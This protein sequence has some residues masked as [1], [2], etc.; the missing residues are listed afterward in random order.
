MIAEAIGDVAGRLRLDVGEARIAIER[1]NYP[2]AEARLESIIAAAR[3]AGV[4][5]V[6]ARA[7]HDRGLVAFKRDHTEAAVRYDFEALQLFERS[8]DQERAL[9]DVAVALLEMGAR[10]DARRA[11]EVLFDTA[12]WQETK[13]AAAINLMEIAARDDEWVLGS[14]RGDVRLPE[15]APPPEL[16]AQSAVV[17]GDG[18]RRFRRTAS[19]IEA[20]E[21]AI[22]LAA[23][24]GLTN[25]SNGPR[26]RVRPSR[27][28]RRG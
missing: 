19:A 25:T 27:K 20:Y 24:A 5:E 10:A 21:V 8:D 4:A 17:A 11:F 1:G 26:R 7:L 22:A 15:S 28:C 2:D 13:W 3:S 12:L 6:T 9:H 18:Y 23:T 16:A 14:S